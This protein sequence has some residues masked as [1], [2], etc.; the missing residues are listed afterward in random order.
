[1]ATRA[2]TKKKEDAKPK[3]EGYFARNRRLQL[4]AQTKIAQDSN[5]KK[6]KSRSTASPSTAA[7]RKGSNAYKP[8]P[9]TSSTTTPKTTTPK[10][11]TPKTTTPKAPAAKITGATYGIKS[12]DTLSAIAKR[13]GTT[14]AAIMSANPSIKD[15]NKIQAGKSLKMPSKDNGKSATQAD[16]DHVKKKTAEAKKKQAARDKARATDKA[17]VEAKKEAARNIR[18][19]GS[20]S[21][22]AY[23][24]PKTTTMK[25]KDPKTGITREYQPRP[26]GKGFRNFNLKK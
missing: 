4:E 23:K 17:G 20:T 16:V 19:G 8:K 1:M 26:G 9:T 24:T 13:A 12:G 11:T 2:Q 18:G 3:K 6:V 25:K 14:V 21:D 5:K 10:T 15:K 22:S 7:D